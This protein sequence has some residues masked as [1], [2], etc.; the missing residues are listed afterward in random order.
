MLQTALDPTIRGDCDG[1]VGRFRNGRI[2]VYAERLY[3]ER[4]Y[5]SALAMVTVKAK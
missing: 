3:A 1:G 2:D 4:S 5:H